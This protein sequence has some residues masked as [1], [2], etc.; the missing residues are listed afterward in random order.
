MCASDMPGLMQRRSLIQLQLRP[1]L[2][3]V[4]LAGS[5]TLWAPA[6]GAEGLALVL[7]L[8]L[9][10]RLGE[11]VQESLYWTDLEPVSHVKKPS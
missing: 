4:N 8:G 3:R 10:L 5:H 7:G 11:T 6:E 9:G 1:Q 2:P